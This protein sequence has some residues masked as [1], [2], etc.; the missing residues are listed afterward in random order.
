[1]TWAALREDLRDKANPG[2]GLPACHLPR[3]LPSCSRQ[4]QALRWKEGGLLAKLLLG[5]FSGA[6]G[7]KAAASVM[8]APRGGFSF[9]R[10]AAAASLPAVPSAE[11]GA[12][13][14]RSKQS[15]ALPWPDGGREG[16]CSIKGL[17]SL[18]FFLHSC[19]PKNTD[20]LMPAL[21]R[22]RDEEKSRRGCAFIYGR[23]I[24]T[25]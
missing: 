8:A 15:P 14:P 3:H 25:V 11:E 19:P 1:M 10:G 17:P 23:K 16:A 2:V 24:Q 12:P 9:P 13:P 7:A 18:R 6:S 21:V 4:I 20:V 22:Q 5:C